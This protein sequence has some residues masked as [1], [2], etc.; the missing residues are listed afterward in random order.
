METRD[1][2]IAEDDVVRR[3][4]ADAAD[5]AFVNDRPLAVMRFGSHDEGELRYDLD[6]ASRPSKRRR[7]ADESRGRLAPR[8][9]SSRNG[10]DGG[11]DGGRGI[12]TIMPRAEAGSKSLSLAGSL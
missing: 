6:D 9:E 3:V 10:D 11:K 8:S 7:I 12:G 5:L 1:G 2:R 4:R